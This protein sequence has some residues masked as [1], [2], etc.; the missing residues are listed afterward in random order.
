MDKARNVEEYIA[1]QQAAIASNPDCGTSHYN[2]AVALMGLKKYEEAKIEL[3]TAVECSP[4]LAEAYVQLGAI[5]LNKGDMDG[6][7]HYN[8]LAVKDRKSVV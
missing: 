5:S 6:C 3:M 4:S 7:L 2:L 1:R 8:Q